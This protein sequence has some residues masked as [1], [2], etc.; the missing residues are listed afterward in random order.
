MHFH[1]VP[2]FNVKT[3]AETTIGMGTN[4]EVGSPE[5]LVNKATPPLPEAPHHDST[6]LDTPKGVAFD[7]PAC[8]EGQFTAKKPPPRRLE[9]KWIVLSY[10]GV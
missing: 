7:V 10:I 3:E 1:F 6:H 4:T 2:D 9:V 8:S 5:R